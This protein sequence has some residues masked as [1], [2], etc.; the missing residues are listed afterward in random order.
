M[1]LLYF[2]QL[3]PNPKLTSKGQF[4]YPIVVLSSSI[5]RFPF[6][7]V[8]GMGQ[9]EAAPHRVPLDMHRIFRSDE[10]LFPSC[11]ASIREGRLDRP[12]RAPSDVI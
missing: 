4:R 5:R 8:N 6:T 10:G 7:D 12:L 3:K 2:T 9:D 1:L 11:M